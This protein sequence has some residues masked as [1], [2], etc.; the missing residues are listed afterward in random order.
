MMC[1]G[2]RF[3]QIKKWANGKQEVCHTSPQFNKNQLRPHVNS[4]LKKLYDRTADA[5]SLDGIEQI[6][7]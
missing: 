2:G 3:V 6:A 7:I 1:R 5:M 4:A